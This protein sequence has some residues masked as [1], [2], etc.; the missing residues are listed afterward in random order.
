MVA[1]YVISLYTSVGWGECGWELKVCG[2][3][4]LYLYVLVLVGGECGW[5]LKVCG[6]TICYISMY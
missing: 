4:M 1:P 5:E 2:G 3:T 6:G